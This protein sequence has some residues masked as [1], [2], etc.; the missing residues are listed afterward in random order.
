MFTLARMN[1]N[2]SANYYID[3]IKAKETETNLLIDFSKLK[4]IAQP[5]LKGFERFK[6]EVN[7]ILVKLVRSFK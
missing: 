2:V 4:G 5:E 7:R 1:F 3:K 6:Y